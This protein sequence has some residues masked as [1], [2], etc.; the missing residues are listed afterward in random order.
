MGGCNGGRIISF[1]TVKL[2][3]EGSEL[4]G[5]AGLVRDDGEA[6]WALEV[7]GHCRG[8]D[9]GLDPAA[10]RTDDARQPL[11]RGRSVRGTR[12]FLPCISGRQHGE[13]KTFVVTVRAA[14]GP[15]A[16]RRWCH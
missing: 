8:T 5:L 12:G 15:T 7:I 13:G 11:W 10:P 3:R 9:A 14:R 1:E 4:H 6:D 2:T 16:T